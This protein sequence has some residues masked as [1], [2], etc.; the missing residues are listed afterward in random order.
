LGGGQP[1]TAQRAVVDGAV[2]IAGN[3]G[4]LSVFSVNQNPA[5]PMAHAAVAFDHRIISVDFHLPFGIGEFE[6]SHL[7][8]PFG[9]CKWSKWWDA[10]ETR[11]PVR[12]FYL[13]I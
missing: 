4:H 2:R 13:I 11:Y 6:F 10:Y 12:I 5:P 9:E 3:F 1:L 8:F 7:R